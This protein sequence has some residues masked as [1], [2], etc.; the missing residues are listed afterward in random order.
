MSETAYTCEGCG[1]HVVWYSD[2][3][4]ELSRNQLCATC[5]YTSTADGI[6]DLPH[7]EFLALR[8]MLNVRVYR[9]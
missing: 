6:H 4:T 9:R 3:Q 2:T 5:E 7:G 8:S 1:N